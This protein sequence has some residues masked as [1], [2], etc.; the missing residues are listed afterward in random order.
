MCYML[1]MYKRCTLKIPHEPLYPRSTCGAM[2]FA[3]FPQCFN[4]FSMRKQHESYY[5]CN[6]CK[7]NTNPS[8]LPSSRWSCFWHPWLKLCCK[9]QPFWNYFWRVI[10]SS[11]VCSFAFEED[12]HVWRKLQISSDRC[13]QFP[14]WNYEDKTIFL[15]YPFVLQLISLVHLINDK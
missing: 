3:R 14:I 10:N 8:I 13:I 11:W 4:A 7:K 5:Q 9:E 1:K 15:I 6:L 2:F 12:R